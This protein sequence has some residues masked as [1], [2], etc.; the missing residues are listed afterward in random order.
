VA[1]GKM[2]FAN[3]TLG[4]FHILMIGALFTGLFSGVQAV[5]LS[6]RFLPALKYLRQKMDLFADQS[7][8]SLL[9]TVRTR[10]LYDLVQMAESNEAHFRELAQANSRYAATISAMR[11]GVEEIANGNLLVDIPEELRETTF[12]KVFQKM[13][14]AIQNVIC[15]ARDDVYH[16]A[17]T[18][19]KAAMLSQQGIQN[20]EGETRAIDTIAS[21]MHQMM[22]N[23]GTMIKNIH[24]QTDSLDQTVAALDELVVSG[25]QI[26]AT[27]DRLATASKET[28]YAV[29]EIHGFMEEIEHHAQSSAEISGNVST[30]VSDGLHS[31]AA[32]IEGIETIK[33]TVQDVAAAIQRLGEESKRIGE[34][35]E[36]I[37]DV[38]EQTN[39][40]ALNASIIA[41]QAGE[42]GRGFSVVAGEI[43]ELAERTRTSTEEIADIIGSV[44]AKVTQG[45]T[46][47]QS[48]LKAVD[49]G[50]GLANE[51]G[52]M[53]KKI[54]RG[55]Q[56][57]RKMIS[58]MASATVTQTENSLQLKAF[59]EEMRTILTDVYTTLTKQAQGTARLTEDMQSLKQMTRQIDQMAAI[60]LQEADTLVQ[61]MEHVQNLVKSHS[62][63]VDQFVQF[64]EELGELEGHLVE[65]LGQFFV[66][67]EQLSRDFDPNRPT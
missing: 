24:L 50:V 28:A 54:V 65:H 14:V 17:D 11:R 59:T 40:L 1:G 10:E 57:S 46:T 19:A 4:W 55:I 26:N 47:M 38:A 63:I 42:H 7:S 30:Q 41:A 33:S 58:T 23:L 31:V 43:K 34:I 52:N 45:M 15:H 20:A 27:I 6:S 67:S 37:N 56:A 51:S 48:C 29:D 64:P 25:E 53:L 32:V 5:F 2:V 8:A 21:S 22:D 66:T 16:L 61:D 12:F 60:Q 36:V 62:R 39:L 44:Q 18:R 35:L 13:T 3:S 9:H 49:G